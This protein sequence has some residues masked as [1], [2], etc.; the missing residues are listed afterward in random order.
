MGSPLSSSPRRHRIDGGRLREPKLLRSANVQVVRAERDSREE[1]FLESAEADRGID[2]RSRRH[3][4][5]VAG[6]H[7]DGSLD[8]PALARLVFDVPERRKQLE[9]ILHP[10]IRAR[11]I[12]RL[13]ENLFRGQ[14]QSLG[15]S[16]VYGGQVLGQDP[17]P[18]ENAAVAGD[19]IEERSYRGE[20]VT[21]ERGEER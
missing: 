12:E 11:L 17:P 5:V 15:W 1:L 19:P 14:S 21:R 6:L 8:R 10:V 3:Q 4:P 20:A 2:H 16:R 9:A 7:A 13:E 18:A